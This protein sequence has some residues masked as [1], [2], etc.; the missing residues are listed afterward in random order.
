MMQ[1]VCAGALLHKGTTTV[2]NPGYSND[3]LAALHIIEQLGAT[4]LRNYDGSISISGTGV[5]P[6]T[7]II[8]CGESGLSTRLFAPIAALSNELVTITGHG[9]LLQR[10]M[11]GFSQFLPLL[12][13]ELLDFSGF[14][15]LTLKGPLKPADVALDGSASSQYLTGLLFSM[16]F[17]AQEPVR[18]KAQ[19]LKSRP[20]IDLSLQVLGK[21]GKL[22]ENNDYQEFLIDPEKFTVVGDLSVTIESDWSSAAAWI[23]AGALNGEIIINHLDKNSTQADRHILSVLA[24]CGVPHHWE[25]NALYIRSSQNLNPFL[26]DA[27][28]CPDLFPVLG[29]LAA[30]CSGTSKVQGVH[31]LIHK[32]SNRAETIAKMLVQLGVSLKIEDDTIEITGREVLNSTVI[33]SYNDHRIAMAAAVASLRT[34]Q[35]IVI[36]NPEAVAK[37]YPRFFDDLQS[38]QCITFL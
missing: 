10:P 33:S 27:T 32:E 5:M 20:Y 4:V 8:N 15:P 36:E 6:V 18:V 22:I 3:D 31:R 26:F 1:R 29:V 16:A 21:F 35:G 17:A 28:H 7:N 19:N 24:Q 23:V 11:Q 9:S 13:V 12:G 38:L 37:S 25:D 34:E 14:L 30:C 2:L